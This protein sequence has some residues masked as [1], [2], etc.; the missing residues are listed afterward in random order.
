MFDVSEFLQTS[1]AIL[2]VAAAKEILAAREILTAVGIKIDKVR[3]QSDEN[4]V[5][6][7]EIKKDIR[8]QLGMIAGLKWVLELP[9]MAAEFKK[10]REREE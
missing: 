3:R 10:S 2:H 1:E 5:L 4:P 9:V 7:D 6:S 8:Y